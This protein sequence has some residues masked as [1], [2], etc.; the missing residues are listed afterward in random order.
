MSGNR[1]LQ[2]PLEQPPLGDKA[3]R[4]EEYP[5]LTRVGGGPKEVWPSCAVG[6][7]DEGTRAEACAWGKQQRRPMS[8]Q[9][10]EWGVETPTLSPPASNLRPQHPIG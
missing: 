1:R 9:G 3:R 10:S 2:D 8:Q 5:G 4:T 7:D 6:G